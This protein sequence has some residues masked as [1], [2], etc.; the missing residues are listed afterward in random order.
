MVPLLN[1]PF[2]AYQLALLRRHGVER[3]VLSCSY[4]VDEIRRTMGDGVDR[5][6]RLDYAVEAEPLGTGGGVRNAADLLGDTGDDAGGGLVVVL[7]GD[8]LTDVDLSA[9]LCFHA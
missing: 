2:L 6:V 5:G 9:M 7:N 4:L 1:V 3:A 8:V